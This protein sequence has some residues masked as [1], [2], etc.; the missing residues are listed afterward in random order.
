MID[1]SDPMASL[2]RFCFD[3]TQYLYIYMYFCIHCILGCEADEVLHGDSCYRFRW[4]TIHARHSLSP[5]MIA[6]SVTVISCTSNQWTNKPFW[7]TIRR[8]WEVMIIGL[9]SL[10][11]KHT[12]GRM[13]LNMI[14]SCFRSILTMA[15]TAFWL[16]V[17][18]LKRN[19]AKHGGISSANQWDH[20]M[21]SI[22]SY[23]STIVYVLP[24]LYK[25]ALKR[26]QVC[27]RVY[28]RDHTV[29]QVCL[30][31]NLFCFTVW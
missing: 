31:I 23:M 24:Y 18:S 25:V 12:F 15:V 19:A 17:V 28:M 27:L 5:Y 29:L 26:R 9:D 10:P 1:T 20:P 13:G 7:Q 4:Q 16:I 11:R 8:L 14:P 2:V 21:V 22:H 3:L 30:N 6:Y